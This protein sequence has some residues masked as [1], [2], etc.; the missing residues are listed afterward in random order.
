[1]GRALPPVCRRRRLEI[2][3]YLHPSERFLRA[4]GWRNRHTDQGPRI[5]GG[6]GDR[7]SRTRTSFAEGE[8]V[9]GCAN[10][11]GDRDGGLPE[12]LH[13]HRTGEPFGVKQY[14]HVDRADWISDCGR[15]RARRTLGWHTP[16]R[17]RAIYSFRPRIVGTL[18]RR[19]PERL[20]CACRSRESISASRPRPL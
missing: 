7:C 12:P 6:D 16:I 9:G 3:P 20:A 19:S 11:L 8:M 14:G 18:A 10:V 15:G 5:R 17:Y 1:M 13:G 4:C 2:S